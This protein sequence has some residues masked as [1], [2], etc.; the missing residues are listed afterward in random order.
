MAAIEYVAPRQVVAKKVVK[1]SNGPEPIMPKTFS[2]NA[3]LSE[4]P[5]SEIEL[6]IEKAEFSQNKEETDE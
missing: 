2:S 1:T 4:S 3:Q 6:S 5:K